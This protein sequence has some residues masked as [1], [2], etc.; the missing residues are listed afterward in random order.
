MAVDGGAVMKG[1]MRSGLSENVTA[2]TN[3]SAKRPA[4]AD[5]AMVRYRQFCVSAALV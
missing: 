5:L 4:I 1:L 2:A 3:S